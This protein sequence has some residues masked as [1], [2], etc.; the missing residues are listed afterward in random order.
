VIR[1]SHHLKAVQDLLRASPVVAILGPRQIG[2]STLAREVARSLKGSTTYFDLESAADQRRLAEPSHTLAPLKGLVILDEIQLRPDIFPALRVLADRPRK[3]ARFL[4]LGSASPHLLK[5]SS[6]TLAG[7]IA[8]YE[9]PGLSLDEVS[10]KNLRR[11]WLRGGFPRAFVARTN[12]ESA[13]WRR[14][15]VRTFLERDLPQ[16]E[17]RTPASALSRFWSMLAHVHGQTMNWSE[18]GRS[19]AVAD[20]T[21]RDYVD[22][23]ESTLVVRTL[24]PWHENIS[25]RQVKAPKV[26]VRDSGLLHTLLDIE[27]QDDLD[28]HPKVGASWE[29]FV[30]NEVLAR[31][32]ARADQSYF[33][34]TH[35]GAELD[36]LIVQGK[37]RRG[38]E[39]KLTD[40]PSVT[41]SMKAALNDLRLDSIDVIHAGDETYPL[42]ERIRA[43]AA[44]RILKDVER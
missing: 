11:L 22:I 37:T 40:A 12:G 18:L 25:K 13:R 28:V 15:F 27:T 21:V 1:R 44:S 36:L 8:F 34:A 43:V 31:T 29:G 23:L 41:P 35:A 30:M 3:P 26:F 17:I 20:T 16:L 6:E 33:W 39:M 2:K 24:K 32:G 14:D 38:F 9:L 10:T 19:M 42:G 4:V 7:R 5:Q